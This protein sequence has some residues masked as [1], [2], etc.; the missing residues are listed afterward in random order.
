MSVTE[1]LG[2]AWAALLLQGSKDALKDVSSDANKPNTHSL[3]TCRGDL[4][5]TE[6]MKTVLWNMIGI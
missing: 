4:H 5:I 2:W 6:K 3:G 1:E